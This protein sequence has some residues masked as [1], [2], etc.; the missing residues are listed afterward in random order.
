MGCKGHWEEEACTGPLYH[1]H[2][3]LGQNTLLEWKGTG[4]RTGA[5][6]VG[7]ACSES[8]GQNGGEEGVRHLLSAEA[9]TK[10]VNLSTAPGTPAR[11]PG[12]ST[13]LAGLWSQGTSVPLPER[14]TVV[15]KNRYGSHEV[16]K[17][18]AEL[19][20]QNQIQ[21]QRNTQLC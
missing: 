12:P 6:R 1:P 4:R 13:P 16:L 15:Y 20:K 9:P 10:W 21:R 8:P 5:H 18:T 17:S 14:L 19:D 2:L 11:K 7:N 3:E